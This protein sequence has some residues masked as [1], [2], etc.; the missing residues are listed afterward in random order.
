MKD[1]IRIQ[2]LTDLEQTKDR[3]LRESLAR[4]QK[5]IG[6]D[7]ATDAKQSAQAIRYK[8]S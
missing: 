5:R 1:E 6:N 2:N 3:E 7:L 8:Y 4:L